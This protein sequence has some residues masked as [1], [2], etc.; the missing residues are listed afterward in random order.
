MV[1]DDNDKWANGQDLPI[2]PPDSPEQL[3]ERSKGKITDVQSKKESVK[4]SK[5]L[6]DSNTIKDEYNKS[7]EVTKD[8]KE[9][10]ESKTLTQVS[11]QKSEPIITR[12]DIQKIIKF[13]QNIDRATQEFAGFTKSFDDIGYSAISKGTAHHKRYENYYDVIHTITTA[14]PTD[15]NDF[16]SNVYNVERVYEALQRYS[17]I[18]FVSNSGTDTLF[19]I[20]SHRGRTSFSQE[21]PIFPGEVKTYYNTYELR[22]RSPTAGLPYRITEYDL[23]S[24]FNSTSVPVQKGVL[25]VSSLPAA[26]TNWL[27]SDITPISTPTTF[28]IDVA[29]SIAGIFSAQV[30]RGGI[31]TIISFNNGTALTTG[32]LYHFTIKV[33]SGDTINFQYSTTGANIQFL[34]VQEVDTAVA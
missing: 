17:D 8:P 6:K 30:T 34:R 20:V 28:G 14:G 26:N 13:L 5:D 1:N 22:L 11:E 3:G 32:A 4:N 12:S 33:F 23:T 25:H 10:K 19:V 9:L 31:A 18:I 29:V 27:A 24:V 15:P 21:A 7:K 2:N 16:D